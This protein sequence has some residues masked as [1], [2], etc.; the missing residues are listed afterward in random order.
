[1]ALGV[2]CAVASN[3]SLAQPFGVEL[4]NTLMPASGGMGGASLA[5]P[6]DLQSA[7]NGNPATLSQFK[8]TQFSFGGGWA[9]ATYD[10][11]QPVALPLLGITPFGG[12]SSLQGTGLGNIG[13]T[14]ELSALGL[15]VTYGLGFV[16]NAG[17]GVDFR[18]IAAANG[19]ASDYV[20]LDIV[21]AAS[22]SVTDQFSVGA[23]LVLGTS[24][25]DGPFVGISSMTPDYALRGSIGA[26]YQLDPCTTLGAYW[27]TK[28]SFTFH[29]AVSIAG[30]PFQ[31]V[32]LDHPDN[33][34]L[35]IANNAMLDGR[36]LLAVDVLFKQYSQADFFRAIYD[37]Q[38][39][40]QIGA[41]YS[42][43]C[44]VRLR[45]GYAYAENI[46]RDLPSLTAGG[47]VP[48]SIE[49]VQAQFAAINQHRVTAGVGVRDVLPGIDL[50][51][52][53]GGMFEESD[54]FGT[55]TASVA[56]YWLGAGLTWRFGRGACDDVDAP[57]DWCG[58][59]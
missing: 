44:R 7:I 39:V 59:E 19:T 21:N 20:A 57:D 15:P 10:V 26:A 33:F 17:A 30:G 1:V 54:T 29:D 35:G 41:Q 50:D 49:Y 38:W 16:G 45:L 53:A 28:K 23:S 58:L 43:N 37:D 47:I 14:Q 32:H 24:F 56:S 5:R 2:L 31:D 48:P 40:F 12:K 25:M 4:H 36:L 3:E 22:V 9:E 42:P 46:M 18:P 8:G 51:L 6:Q 11:D 52:F 34:G 13:I 27:Q 55:T